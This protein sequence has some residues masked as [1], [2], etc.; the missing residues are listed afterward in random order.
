VAG[1]AGELLKTLN[2]R[3]GEKKAENW[4]D[5]RPRALSG[6]LRRIAPNLHAAWLRLLLDPREGR[7]RNRIIELSTAETAGDHPPSPRRQKTPNRLRISPRTVRTVSP[8]SRR[9]RPQKLGIKLPKTEEILAA[10]TMRTIGDGQT[11]TLSGRVFPDE[12]RSYESRASSNRCTAI[13]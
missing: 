7:N 10:R 6:K 11:L 13:R 3:G 2:E 12:G 4:V 9:D 5:E 8:T 1:T